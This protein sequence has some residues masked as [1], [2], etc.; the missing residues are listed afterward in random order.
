MPESLSCFKAISELRGLKRC[1]KVKQKL[2]ADTTDLHSSGNPCAD[3]PQCCVNISQSIS[4]TAARYSLIQEKDES[5]VP[6][7]FGKDFTE[8]RLFTVDW[9]F[10][11]R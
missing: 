2:F 9:S 7:V 8:T 3:D 10:T 4:G 11:P 6:A 1:R 5:T